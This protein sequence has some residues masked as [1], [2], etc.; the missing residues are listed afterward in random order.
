MPRFQTE[1]LSRRVRFVT[2]ARLV[3]ELQPTA[4]QVRFVRPPTTEMSSMGL[5]S[6]FRNQSFGRLARKEASAIRFEGRLSRLRLVQAA[7]GAGLVTWFS[8]ASSAVRLV[9][10]A[11][12]SRSVTPLPLTL[13]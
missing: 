1:R 4:S 8:A 3:T 9:R 13:R 6:R 10:P 5:F 12:G 2:G 11:S 7:R